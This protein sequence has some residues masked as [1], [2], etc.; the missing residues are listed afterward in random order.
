[1][2][3]LFGRGSGNAYPV[4]T[5]DP[6]VTLQDKID[7]VRSLFGLDNGPIDFTGT[8]TLGADSGSATFHFTGTSVPDGGSSVLLLSAFFPLAFFA[9]KR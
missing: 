5:T 3:F 8:Y 4:Y 6:G 2:D 9:R 7:G 1:V